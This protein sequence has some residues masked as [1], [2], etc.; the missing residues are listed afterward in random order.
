[1]FHKR[2]QEKKEERGIEDLISKKDLVKYNLEGERYLL[3]K[4]KIDR[5]EEIRNLVEIFVSPL[6]SSDCNIEGGPEFFRVCKWK[7]E[8]KFFKEVFTISIRDFLTFQPDEKEI[9]IEFSYYTTSD[10]S[11]WELDRLM[12]LGKL[13]ELFSNKQDVEQLKKDVKE[14]YTSYE[15]INSKV[16][17]LENQ[18]SKI[19]YE[20]DEVKKQSIKETLL[21]GYEFE[22]KE[23]QLFKFKNTMQDHI[24]S[25]KVIGVSK[26]GKTATIEYT[27]FIKTTGSLKYDSCN[28]KVNW[29]V[30]EFTK[31]YY[32]EM[33]IR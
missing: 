31:L 20:I 19:Q 16:R 22:F 10:N 25:I 2:V 29:L 5:K 1:M 24:S 17:D 15:G 12:K 6:L 14:V 13:A 11:D 18:L 21:E 33:T 8:V 23:K 9:K 26:T 32:K 4:K 30:K 28:V 27:S 3:E 7:E